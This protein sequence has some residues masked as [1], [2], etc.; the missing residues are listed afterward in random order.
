MKLLAKNTLVSAVALCLAPGFIMTAEAAASHFDN[1]STITYTVSVTNNT[2]AGVLTDL[3]IDDAAFVLDNS[4][5]DFSG[6]GVATYTPGSVNPYSTEVMG[7][8]TVNGFADVVY[9]TFADLLFE[10][11]GSDLF[12]I[13]VILA[14]DLMASVS[15]MTAESSVSID[16]F[17]NNTG[18]FSG[19]EVIDVST[20]GVLSDSLMGSDTFSFNL[21]AFETEGILT[22]IV[23]TGIAESVQ[24]SVPEP[25]IL[26]LMLSSIIALPLY[27]RKKTN[28]YFSA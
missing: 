7:D 25:G 4:F 10:N 12:T 5:T 3:I 28:S 21:G 11:T 6:D 26:V 18:G 20:L 16:Y 23:N 19:S 13:D 9:E 2:N 14:Y 8:T 17:N 15:G 1:K 22:S 24:P 27:R